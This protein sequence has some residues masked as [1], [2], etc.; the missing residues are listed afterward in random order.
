[1]Q[2]LCKYF[3]CKIGLS[4][5]S[6]CQWAITNLGGLQHMKTKIDLLCIGRLYCVQEV[7][8]FFEKVFSISV[9]A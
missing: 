8:I 7:S 5:F 9:T 6:P 3:L 4:P 2:K 1:M